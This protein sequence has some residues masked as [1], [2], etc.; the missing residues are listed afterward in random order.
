MPGGANAIMNEA[1]GVTHL[2]EEELKEPAPSETVGQN[3]PEGQTVPDGPF[4]LEG[5]STPEAQPVPNAPLA[6]PC[7]FV[8]YFGIL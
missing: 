8:I 6:Q 1:D 5:L 7:F 4:T 3:V 2:V